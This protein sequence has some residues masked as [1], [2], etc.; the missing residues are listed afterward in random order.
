MRFIVGIDLSYNQ[1][2]KIMTEV[3][4]SKSIGVSA[5]KVWE[6]LSSFRGIENYSPI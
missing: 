4:V 6:T 5:D 1:N 3:I 2:K